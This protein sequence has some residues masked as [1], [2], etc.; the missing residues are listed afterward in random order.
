LPHSTEPDDASE[1][2]SNSSNQKANGSDKRRL[3]HNKFAQK[4]ARAKKPERGPHIC[5]QRSLIGQTGALH[6]ELISVIL[7]V[8][9]SRHGIGE[10]GRPPN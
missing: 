5:E 3:P 10:S 7:R 6:S 2:H 8:G 9:W 1:Q 4:E